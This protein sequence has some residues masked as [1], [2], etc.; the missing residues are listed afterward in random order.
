MKVGLFIPCYVDQCYPQVGM[1]T[2]ELL[3]RLGVEVDYPEDQTCCGQPM[4]N[5]GCGDAAI[6][7]IERFARIFGDHEHVVCPSGSCASMVRVHYRTLIGDR[8]SPELRARL[9]RLARST[10][11]LCEF[12]TDVLELEHASGRFAHKVGLHHSCH[13]LRELRLGS[14]SERRIPRFD[15]VGRLLAGLD[16]IELVEPVRSDECCGFGGTFAV[17]EDAV[18]CAMGRD[19]LAAHERAGA[20]I[21]TAVDMSCLMHLDGLIQRDRRPLRVMHVAEI[22]AAAAAA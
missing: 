5:S 15:K 9:D 6:P 12:L 4:A 21:V 1:A 3:E 16:G 19:R 7:L 14:G 8:A 18:S 20:E 13:G 11:E 2:V 17:T 10:R 22:L